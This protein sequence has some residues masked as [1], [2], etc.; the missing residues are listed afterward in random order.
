M[1]QTFHGVN[2]RCWMNERATP[3]VDSGRNAM[4]D[5]SLSTKSYISF[6]TTS[7]PSPTRVNTARSSRIGVWM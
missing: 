2:G 1:Y 4:V 3:A 7:V 5:P 6:V